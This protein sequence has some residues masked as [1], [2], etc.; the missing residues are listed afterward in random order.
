MQET[1]RGGMAAPPLVLSAPL[2]SH[3][4]RARPPE[5]QNARHRTQPTDAGHARVADVAAVVFQYLRL[6]RGPGGVTRE[7][8]A[9][10]RARAPAMHVTVRAVCACA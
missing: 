8:C 10:G 4:R 3:R 1:G 2:T 5:L 9:C 7:V 6:L